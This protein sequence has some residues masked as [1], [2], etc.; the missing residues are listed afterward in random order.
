MEQSGAKC[1]SGKGRRCHTGDSSGWMD[2]PLESSSVTPLPNK[3]CASMP[4]YHLLYVDILK[5]REMMMKHTGWSRGKP[6]DWKYPKH[7]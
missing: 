2:L 7:Y 6:L 3:H 1:L 4:P 5:I